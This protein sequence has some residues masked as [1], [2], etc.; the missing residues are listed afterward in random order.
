[1]RWRHGRSNVGLRAIA[2]TNGR[3][4]FLVAKLAGASTRGHV[5]ELQEGQIFAERYRL[6]SHLSSGGF[7]KVYRAIQL[8]VDRTVAI[9]ILDP[10]A[11]SDNV[12]KRFELEAKLV[13][14]LRDPHTIT[15]HEF[16]KEG[17][18]FYMVFEYVDG[19]DLQSEL[20][21][22]ALEPD[23]VRRI[24]RQVLLALDEAHAMDVIHRDLK[25]S[26]IMI[27]DH[28]TRNDC[29]KVLD[30]GIAKTVE[31]ESSFQTG[32]TADGMMVGTPRYMAPEQ[33][34]LERLTPATDVYALG[35]VTLEMLTG[36]RPFDALSMSEM[37]QAKCN[38]D[39][40]VPPH[41]PADLR[42]LLTT[43]LQRDPAHRPADAAA[44]LG[45]LGSGRPQGAPVQGGFPLG[46]DSTGT[47][48]VSDITSISKI[49]TA[50][51]VAP[52]AAPSR[53]SPW[54]VLFVVI[55]VAVAAAMLW[56]SSS[57]D[58]APPDEPVPEDTP[59]AEHVT[60]APTDA[61]VDSATSTFVELVTAVGS[62]KVAV[63]SAVRSASAEQQQRG[64]K[65]QETPAAKRKVRR[66]KPPAEPPKAQK[67]KPFRPA[68]V[69]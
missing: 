3:R 6:V 5:I 35:L 4:S 67:S 18:S 32:L 37:V 44:V 31:Q 61:S 10:V 49:E 13:S 39:V 26:N 63:E 53:R 59:P 62:A 64:A 69:D 52:R 23:R 11:A 43:M 57:R 7:A 27:Y 40:H 38:D 8:G 30:F 20:Q 22:G 45:Q 54:I 34:R 17:D 55:A 46:L 2:K 33:L 47:S 50:P 42:D 9:K 56:A 29:V 48:R 16:G 36:A 51:V 24:L 14:Q 28:V 41:L 1:M 21:H 58:E 12:D 19:R 25:P 15:M 66:R 68:P 60:A 65:V